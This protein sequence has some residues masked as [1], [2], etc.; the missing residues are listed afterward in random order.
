MANIEDKKIVKDMTEDYNQKVSRIQDQIDELKQNII[1]DPNLVP[2][3]NERLHSLAIKLFPKMTTHEKKMQMHFKKEISNINIGRPQRVMG[4][5]GIPRVE[6]IIERQ[7]L[8]MYKYMLEK[9]EIEINSV[10]ERI[11]LTASERKRDRI[12]H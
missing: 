7:N 11:G 1:Y 3:L 5:D 4:A 12:I 8:K 6:F 2:K 9:R 10:L